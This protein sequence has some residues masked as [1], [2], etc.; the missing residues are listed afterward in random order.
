MP[1]DSASR[2]ARP[3]SKVKTAQTARTA[4]IPGSALLAAYTAMLRI[5]LF[6]ERTT[7]LFLAGEVKGT[8]HSYIGQEA[9][10]VGVCANLNADDYIGSYHR[11]HGHCLAKGARMDFMMAELMGKSTGYCSGLGGSMHIADLSLGIIGANGIVGAAMP[12]SAGA[13]LSAQLNAK[14]RVA[15]AFFGD[16]AI[17]QGVFH[18]TMNLAAVWKLPLIFVCENNQYALT[19]PR[20]RTTAGNSLAARAEPYGVPGIEIDG[21]DPEAVFFAARDAIERARHGGGPSM[22]EAHTYRWS[23]HSMRANLAEPRPKEEVQAWLA[24]DPLPLT[25]DRLIRRRVC[26]QT[27]LDEI[28]VAVRT[29][30]ESAVAFAHESPAPTFEMALAAVNASSVLTGGTLPDPGPRKLTFVQAVNE[31]LRQEMDQD[32]DVIVMGED[33]GT[34]GGIFQATAGLFER[35][36]GNRVR[37]TPISE[38][39]F[40]GCGVGAALTGLRPVVEIQFF[41]FVAMTMDMIVNQAAKLRYMMGGKPIVPLVIRGPQGGG[42]RMAAQHSQSLEIW[43]AHIPGLIVVGPSSPYDA[44][45]LLISAIRD[46][47]PV[48]FL[49]SKLLYTA[50]PDSVPET[51]YAIPLG[52]GIVKREGIDV[53]VVATMAMVPRALAAA[54]QLEREGCSVEVIDPRTFRPLDE[55]LI[56]ESVRKTHRLL[57]VHEACTDYGF[58]AEVAAMVVDKAFD[59][60]DAPIARLGGPPMP[61]PYNDELERASIPTHQR[62]ADA[63]RN[64]IR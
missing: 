19:T 15:V 17:N 45:G 59:W 40:V 12:L 48:I 56:L 41:D 6:E 23:Q 62:I 16:G 43:F 34:T 63:V 54:N 55:E 58:G 20:Q 47:N 44:K 26:T 31:A 42:F 61:M 24:R 30:V 32:I 38:A 53:T 21:N 57:I 49:E 33:I 36:G 37:D 14:G 5:R 46:N 7:E 25:A 28:Q 51:P 35:F 13:A 52:R 2:R 4:R 22:I 27:A 18:E 64:L 50:P 11:G 8:A 29:E 1:P 10:A 3:M 39:T 60:L 9:I